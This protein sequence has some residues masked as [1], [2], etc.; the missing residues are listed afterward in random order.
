VTALTTIKR[1][2]RI[3]D[4]VRQV[5]IVLLFAFIVVSMGFEI[6]MRNL[7]WTNEMLRYLNIWV[8]FLGA[9]LAVKHS[10]HLQITFLFDRILGPKKAVGQK[11]RI[12][13]VIAFLAVIAFAGVMKTISVAHSQPQSLDI[14]MAWFYLAIPVGCVLMMM[15]YL[16]ILVCGR[17]P[18]VDGEAKNGGDGC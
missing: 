1:I 14:S 3:I 5:A 7:D 10:E 8:I 16:L 17:H 15:D 18:F 9:S 13:A 6:V 2:Y 11:V 4:L 12:G